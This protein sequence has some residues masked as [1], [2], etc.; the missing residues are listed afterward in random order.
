MNLV[1]IV[2]TVLVITISSCGHGYYSAPS[3]H[4]HN[5][6]DDYVYDAEVNWNNKL[7]YK[8]GSERR[9]AASGAMTLAIKNKSDF[10]GPVHIKFKNGKGKIITKEFVFK[11]ENLPKDYSVVI[12]FMQNDVEYFIDDRD[13]KEVVERN[14]KLQ[15]LYEEYRAVCRDKP[16]KT[17]PELVL[18]PNPEICKKYM[19]I[20]KPEN[21]A[22]LEKFR[23]LYAIQEAKREEYRKERELREAKNLE[24]Y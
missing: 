13:V 15:S 8:I 23:Q 14:K 5:L 24:D 2:L 19:P 9:P 1:K 7:F 21:A 4:F 20:Y 12:Y 11:N 18:I 6:S 22:K 17:L 10:F 16:I 3:L